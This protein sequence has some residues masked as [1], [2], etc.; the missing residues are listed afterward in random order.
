MQ[1]CHVI[2]IAIMLHSYHRES[3]KFILAWMGLVASH[4]QQHV[5]PEAIVLQ[6]TSEDA[7]RTH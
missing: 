2:Y 4:S 6:A 1:F 5:P 7:V 3:V